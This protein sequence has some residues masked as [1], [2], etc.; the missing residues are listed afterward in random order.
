MNPSDAVQRPRSAGPGSPP[1][2]GRR[3]GPPDGGAAEAGVDLGDLISELTASPEWS[4]EQRASRSITQ[5]D[6]LRAVVTALRAGAD[7]HNDDPDES[8]TIQGLVGECVVTSDQGDIF[9]GEG[10]LVAVPRGSRWELVARTDAAVLLTV[11]RG[12]ATIKG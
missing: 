12:R 4:T 11:G 8:V 9:V 2:Q 5:T 1:L 7:L 3:A 6:E 10:T